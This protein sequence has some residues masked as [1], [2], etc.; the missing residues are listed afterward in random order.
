MA[1]GGSESLLAGAHDMGASAEK[2]PAE[3]PVRALRNRIR[4]AFAAAVAVAGG[5]FV[6][7]V[8]S[9]AG[10]PASAFGGFPDE[11]AHYIGGVLMR[12][13]LRNFGFRDP[14]R[15]AVQYYSHTP[16]F[17]I[18][19]WPPLYYVLEGIWM[20][21]FGIGRSSVLWLNVVA[22]AALSMMVF[23]F[24]RPLYGSI[25]GAAA[26]LAVLAV[27]VVQWS[28][29]LVMV[30]LAC[31][32]LALAALFLW[33]CYLDQR[34]WTWSLL[35]G[36]VLSLAVL[37]KTSAFYALFVPPAMIALRR[38][39]RLLAG[40]SF[41]IA[42]V[43]FALLFGPWLLLSRRVLL[44]NFVGLQGYS[45]VEVASGF[46][47]RLWEQCGF[48][49]LLALP[50]IVVA[51]ARPRATPAAELCLYTAFLALPFSIFL[52]R[53]AVQERLL[54]AAYAAVAVAAFGSVRWIVSS[55]RLPQNVAAAATALLAAAFLWSHALEFRFPPANDLRPVVSA[56]KDSEGPASGSALV[57]S[58]LEGPWIAEFVQADGGGGRRTLVRP[59]KF[60]ASESWNGTDYQIRYSS[61][62]DLRAV[63]SDVPVRYIIIDEKAKEYPHDRTL[64][65]FLRET[66]GTWRQRLSS[67]RFS[68]Y[69]NTA[70][71]PQ[72]E[73]RVSAAMR[74]F[75]SEMLR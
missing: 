37:T 4:L 42:P 26:G 18:G 62:Q 68:V 24:A 15:Y 60:L 13:F 59:T 16:Y 30:D 47:F 21:L 49:L 53:V 17:A 61:V 3:K 71:S 35:F 11:P 54:I 39:W 51:I 40:K 43:A 58:R 10:A 50:R 63:F 57:P 56:I 69:E 2:M 28:A 45:P 66:A 74:R 31:N 32:T 73:E 41:W 8:Q 19:V 44:L 1:P 33:G 64:K 55:L 27:P 70:W 5:A 67:G 14:V 65:A 52:A 23:V 6:L 34:R 72:S 38:D 46:A 12:D 36:V 7:W 75:A 48:L 20:L 25:A 9:A 29:C 22:G